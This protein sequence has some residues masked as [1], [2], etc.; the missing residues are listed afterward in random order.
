MTNS[1]GIGPV[2]S[3]ALIAC[4]C[5]REPRIDFEQIFGPQELPRLARALIGGRPDDEVVSSDSRLE[6]YAIRLRVVRGRRLQLAED[7]PITTLIDGRPTAV[8]RWEP[9]PRRAYVHGTVDLRSERGGWALYTVVVRVT[10]G[11]LKGAL[12][13][14]RDGHL[15]TAGRSHQ[16]VY[17]L[18]AGVEI[19]EGEIEFQV[20]WAFMM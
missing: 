14:L 13:D 3:L 7:V 15:D 17:E 8:E 10:S 9:S 2:V 11:E 12:I 16:A 18:P 20:A 19:G 5:E 1:R 6:S 4:S